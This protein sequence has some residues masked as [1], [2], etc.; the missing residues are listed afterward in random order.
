[1]PPPALRPPLRRMSD[2]ERWPKTTAR[3]ADGRTKKKIPQIRL[4]MAKPLVSGGPAGA[5]RD[6][7]HFWQKAASSELSCWHCG[8]YFMS[9]TS[10][11]HL[12]ERTYPREWRMSTSLR[13]GTIAVCEWAAHGAGCQT[14]GGKAE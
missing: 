4:A 14:L 5:D 13:R 10:G 3:I 9:G 6:A 8:Q 12:L 7:P 1:M 11:K 2:R